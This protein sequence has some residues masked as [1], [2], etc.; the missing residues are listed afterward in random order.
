LIALVI[1]ITVAATIVVV[2]I[3]GWPLWSRPS[4]IVI[5]L[6]LYNSL[7][8]F[9][10][11]VSNFLPFFLAG[12]ALIGTR[13]PDLVGIFQL[14][15]LDSQVQPGRTRIITIPVGRIIVRRTKSIIG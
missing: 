9:Y 7:V 2:T 12:Q 6:S 5:L 1:A 3:I 4:V 15:V 10:F 8:P 14:D 11:Q 13:T